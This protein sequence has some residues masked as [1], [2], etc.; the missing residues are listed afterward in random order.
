MSVLIFNPNHHF[1]QQQQ[2]HQQQQ[3]F[4]QQQQHQQNKQHKHNQFKDHLGHRKH[5][6]IQQLFVQQQH[7]ININIFNN[8]D[9]KRLVNVKSDTIS[10]ITTH[11]FTLINNLFYLFEV[12]TRISQDYEE[13]GVQN[14]RTNRIYGDDG[15]LPKRRG[16]G[17]EEDQSGDRAATSER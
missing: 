5:Q 14:R 12:Y 15:L 16:Q 7:R 4:N 8:K 2:Q 1:H 6:L 13:N 17:A 3:R 11:T 9:H 10:A